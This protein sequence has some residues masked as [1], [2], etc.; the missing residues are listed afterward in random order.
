MYLFKTLN[1]FRKHLDWL[2][3]GN[4]KIGF[5]PTMGALHEGHLSLVRQSIAECQFTIVSIF[6][7]PKQF[8]ERADLEKYPRSPSKDLQMLAE[9]GCDIVFMPDAAQI[10]PAKEQNAT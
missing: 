7:N 1:A 6:V 10:Y 4:R 2:R 3:S 5:V 8:N 9:V